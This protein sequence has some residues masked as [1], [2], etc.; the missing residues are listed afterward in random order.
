MTQKINEIV[1]DEVKVNEQNKKNVVDVSEV[2]PPV[3][4]ERPAYLPKEEPKESKPTV[5]IADKVVINE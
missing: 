2:D 3:V 4:C 1:V 5:V